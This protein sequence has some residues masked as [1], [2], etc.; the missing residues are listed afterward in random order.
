MNLG[1][2]DADFAQLFLDLRALDCF[3]DQQMHRLT[4]DCGAAHP[5]HLVHGVECRGHVVA[6]HV[7]PAR[8]GW[9]H[10]RQFFQLVRLTAHDQF[11]QV[12]VAH[13]IAAFGFIH[14]MGRHKQRHA[15]TR[16]LEKQILQ[17]APGDWIDTGGRLI[18]EEHT[19]PVHERT[20]HGQTLTPATGELGSAPVYVRL[21][22]RCGNH[23]LAPL[24]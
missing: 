7:K 24:V 16:E 12:D 20:S 2:T 19:R 9:I 15:F 21:Q 22:M 8:S 18:K 6:S 13:V 4:E 14:V 3:I 17:F 5:G 11:R 23:F 1:M 10:V